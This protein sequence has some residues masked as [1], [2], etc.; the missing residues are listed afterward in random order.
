MALAT[1]AKIGAGTT[2]FFQDPDAS[3]ADTF[4][5]LENTLEIGD[6]GEEGSFV[7]TTRLKDTT[8]RFA[9]GMTTPPQ[10]NIVLHDVPGD[11]N[12]TKFLTLATN[13]ATVTMKVAV[14]NGRTGVFTLALGGYRV[15]NPAGDNVV[16]LTVS[17]QQSGETTWSFA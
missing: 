17:G 6:T 9:P 15:G 2:I 13:K 12:Q 14:A 1:T 3:G 7:D 10:K 5:E 11:A 4:L 8:R 16:T